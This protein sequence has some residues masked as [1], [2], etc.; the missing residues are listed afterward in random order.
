MNIIVTITTFLPLVGAIGLLI[1]SLLGSRDVDHQKL[2][3]RYRWIT[4]IVTLAT[5]LVS[6]GILAGFDR[7]QPG[8]Q[9]VQKVPWITALGVS[10]YVGIDGISLW[11]VLLTTF[12]MPISILASWS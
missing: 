9:L 1:Y 11:L 5:F 6:L 2:H 4:L 3:D 10:Y 8:P 7:S 12:L